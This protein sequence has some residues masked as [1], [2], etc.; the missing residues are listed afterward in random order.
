MKNFSCTRCGNRLFFENVTCVVCGSP[1][2]FDSETLSTQTLENA[3]QPGLYRRFNFSGQDVHYCANSEHGA[4]NWIV[5]ANGQSPWCV[6][7]ELNRTI[8][9][10]SEPGSLPAWTRLERAKKR[11]V[12]SLLRMGLPIDSASTGRLTFDFLRDAV[13]G[14]EDGVITIDVMEADFVERERQR[15]QLGEP[16]R[17][18]LGHVR[19]ESGHFY[20][21]VLVA[22]GGRIEEFRK[23]FGDESE[24]YAAA[25][26]RHY[27]YGAPA[28]WQLRHVSAYASAH[29][30]EDWAET[31]A[32]YLH[33]LEALDTAAAENMEPKPEGE[34]LIPIDDVYQCKDFDSLLAR[35]LPLTV[36]LNRLSRSMGHADFYPF[37]IS[38]A[39]C[40]KLRFI[41]RVVTERHLSRQE[42]YNRPMATG[43]VS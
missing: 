31:W 14:H 30:W 35:W 41:H 26:S 11:L 33:M 38:E 34:S 8:P 29:P 27:A 37:V 16:Y 19:H 28:D 25:L 5:P 18:L 21:Q 9:N 17:S 1:V 20:W 39:A 43:T 15:E 22:E 2:G 42:P 3:G 13:T 40:D 7:C 10:L 12:Y 24:D 36:A 6:A 32:H 4:C 23:M